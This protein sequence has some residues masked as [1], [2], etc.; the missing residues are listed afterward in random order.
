MDVT[1]QFL[2]AQVLQYNVR[3]GKMNRGLAVSMSY[4]LLADPAQVTPA[5]LKRAH[6]LGWC[7]ELV[8]VGAG[9]LS[10]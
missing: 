3:G 10:W 1:K 4:K 6:I 5:S 9:A 7:I 2:R 8:G